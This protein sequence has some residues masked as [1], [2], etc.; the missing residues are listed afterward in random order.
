MLK[1]IHMWASA[2]A[3]GTRV[4]G[5][6]LCPDWLSQIPYENTKTDWVTTCIFPSG[7]FPQGSGAYTPLK[8]GTL[9]T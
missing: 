7:I 3:S 2:R 1:R 8:S 9:E 4:A 5:A 6:M